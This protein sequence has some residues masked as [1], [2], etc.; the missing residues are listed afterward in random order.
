MEERR[1]ECISHKETI[2]ELKKAVFGNGR[3]GLKE[4]VT[5]L[6]TMI[7]IVITL[8]LA[9]GGLLSYTLFTIAG[10]KK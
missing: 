9:N 3:P 6:E 10:L 1:A 7:W 8:L 5:K 2:E 4:K